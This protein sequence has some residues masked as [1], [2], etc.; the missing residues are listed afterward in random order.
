M[1]GSVRGVRAVQLTEPG[2]PLQEVD[3][4]KPDPGPGDVVVKVEAAGICRS[5]VHYRTG[6]PQ[7]RELPRTLGHEVAGTVVAAGPGIG[8]ATGSRVALHYLVTCGVCEHC[9]AGAEQFCRQQA[10][11]GKERDGGYAEF[12]TVPAVNAYPIP[13]AV[14]IEAAAVMMCSTATSLHAL[15]KARVVPGESVAVFGVGG[16][17][18]SAVQLARL[19]SADAVFAIDISPAKLSAAA[20]YGAVPVD[21]AAAGVTLLERTAGRGVDV[22]LDLVGSASVIRQGLEAL[23]PMG[24]MVAVGLTHEPVP[25]GPYTDLVT[26]ERELIGSSDHT[27][28][29]IAE[30]L[31]LAADGKLE[32]SSIVTDTI[33]LDARAVNSALDTLEA[34]GDSVRTVIVP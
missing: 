3:A 27:G 26:G 13:S 24:R 34:F 23:A 21:A 25:V 8:L 22:A 30:L 16:L 6:F 7:L 11:L 5:D 31:E 28:A 4:E 15:R 10:M 9:T 32:F 1:A 33:P 12:I 19:E 17:G 29:E 18:M 14:A 2:R 20:S